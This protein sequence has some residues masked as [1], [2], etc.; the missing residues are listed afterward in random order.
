MFMAMNFDRA[1]GAFYIDFVSG[2]IL[3]FFHKCHD[4][5]FGDR[6]ALEGMRKHPQRLL[7]HQK[8]R[9]LRQTHENVVSGSVLHGFES[10]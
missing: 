4:F 2:R 10:Q 8:R 6:A 1:M 9:F 5:R 3:P 7:M